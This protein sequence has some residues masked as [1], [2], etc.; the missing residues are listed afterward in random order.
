MCAQTGGHANLRNFVYLRL[1]NLNKLAM[2]SLSGRL[3][4]PI[5]AKAEEKLNFLTPDEVF[6][7]II[8]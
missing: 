2:A 3:T 1:L 7:E 6:S 5:K 4:L 8:L